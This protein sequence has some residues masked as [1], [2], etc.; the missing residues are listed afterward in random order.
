[1]RITF[2][3][4][5]VAVVP[6]FATTVYV[7]ADNDNLYTI[8]PT[9]GATT[10]VGNM[11]AEMTDIALRNG[12]MF[13][14][15]FPVSGPNSL[16]AINPTTGATTL[17]GSTS[18]YLNALQFGSDGTLYGAGGAPGCGPPPHVT[19]CNSLY[20]I[21]TTTG[22]AT[23][24]GTGV[25]NSSGDL[26]SIGGLYL[27]S[28]TSTTDQLFTVDAITGAGTLV[29]DIGF[30]QVYGLGYVPETGTLYGFNDVG[31]NV[32]SINTTT[33]A[34]TSIAQYS[35]S[36][37]ILGA[38]T[39]AT[40][41]EPRTTGILT[42]GLGLLLGVVGRSRLRKRGLDTASVHSDNIQLQGKT[43]S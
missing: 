1:M 10:L 24:V 12:A 22:A 33:G 9:T 23:L 39:D 40:V 8:D 43:F 27:S 17:I 28:A 2:A 37:E 31:N 32:L 21:N 20:T 15:D 30:A 19:A 18:V 13:G 3:M 25:Y 4:A 11:G 16:Y 34:G 38:A 26:E 14:T 41:P 5:L 6:C 29:G 7:S 35:S 42:V 36:F